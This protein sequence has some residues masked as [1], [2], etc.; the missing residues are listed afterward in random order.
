MATR[1][2]G[3]G[4]L[5]LQLRGQCPESRRLACRGLIVTVK[6]IWDARRASQMKLARCQAPHLQSG[7][8]VTPGWHLHEGPHLQAGPQAQDIPLFLVATLGAVDFESRPLLVEFIWCSCGL[9]IGQGP[10]Y[11]LGAAEN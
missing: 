10:L 11:P 5:V 1:D 4:N 7:V 8:Q 6:I 3:S 9:V 2:V